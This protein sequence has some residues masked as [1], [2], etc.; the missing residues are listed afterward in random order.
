MELTGKVTVSVT[1][2]GHDAV[3]TTGTVITNASRFIEIPKIPSDLNITA[4]GGHEFSKVQL[5]N[6]NITKHSVPL[7]TDLLA[8]VVQRV[9]C[10]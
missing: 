7:A 10:Y 2:P 8:S 5:L 3:K 6:I 9:K 4:L 1:G